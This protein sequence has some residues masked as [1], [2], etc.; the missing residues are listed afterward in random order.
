MTTAPVRRSLGCLF[1]TPHRK[2]LYKAALGPG[3]LFKSTPTLVT[4]TTSMSLY[5]ELCL[6]QRQSGSCEG[7]SSAMATAMTFNVSKPL[8]FFPSPDGIYRDARCQARSPAANGVL[9]PLTDSGAMTSDVVTIFKTCGVRPM[10]TLPG[11]NDDVDPSTVNDEPTLD[12]LD[13]EAQTPILIDPN[14][15][16]VDLGNTQEALA[17]IQ[18]A[19]K[20]GLVAR[21]DIFCDSL[22]QAFFQS[23]TSS[24]PPL[25][26]CNLNDPSG[27][28]H[29]LVLGELE[30]TSDLS[31]VAAGLN[32]WGMCG[33]P[34]LV[35]SKINSAG[36]WQGTAQWF[37]QAVQQVTIWDAKVIS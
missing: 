27:G 28:G 22:F 4:G 25:S 14:A 34:A 3:G 5:E 16:L 23:W 20:L 7:Q 30:V 18:A 35:P 10:V 32:S 2:L 24:T 17:V 13:T 31:V 33:S 6:D 37:A 26:S 19:L 9:P 8:P 1:D 15:Y 21:I 29:A 11:V 12:Q 36:H